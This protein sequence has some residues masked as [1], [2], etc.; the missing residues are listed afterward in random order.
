MEETHPPM[1]SLCNRPMDFRTV[2][3]S[4]DANHHMDFVV[5]GIGSNLKGGD[6]LI[7]DFNIPR[8]STEEGKMKAIL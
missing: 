3:T 8:N 6:Q 2:G 5:P 4:T 7:E 1:T